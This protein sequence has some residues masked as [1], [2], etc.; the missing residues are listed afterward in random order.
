VPTVT[1]IATSPTAL[2]LIGGAVLLAV[3]FMGKKAA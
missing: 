1:G 2:L 3:M